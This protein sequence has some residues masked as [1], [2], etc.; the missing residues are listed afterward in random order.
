EKLETKLQYTRNLETTRFQELDDIRRRFQLVQDHA[1]EVQQSLNTMLR[2]LFPSHESTSSLVET[3]LV[4]ALPSQ[5]EIT[6]DESS[7]GREDE[8]YAAVIM[9][10]RQAIYTLEKELNSA[11]DQLK[12]Y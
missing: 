3:L 10:Y 9:C 4:E 2:Q 1:H 12:G 8:Q 7:S 5:A 11:A 6:D